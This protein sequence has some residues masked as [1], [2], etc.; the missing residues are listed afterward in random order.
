MRSYVHSSARA[1][2]AHV[3]ADVCPDA[4][5]TDPRP[6][7]LVSFGRREVL[8]DLRVGRGACAAAG[9]GG[10]RQEQTET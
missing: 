9:F 1:P 8:L 3:E 5:L 10:D 2:C 4:L 7:E 6:L